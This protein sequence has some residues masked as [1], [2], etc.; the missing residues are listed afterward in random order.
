MVLSDFAPIE[1]F[2]VEVA[3]GIFVLGNNV[4][5]LFFCDF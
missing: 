1:I 3:H 2:V 4:E 5:K